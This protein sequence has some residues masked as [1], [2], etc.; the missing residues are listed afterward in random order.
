MAN[1]TLQILDQNGGVLFQ[2][3]IAFIPNSNAQQFMEAAVNQ[4]ANDQTLTFGAQYYGT[5]QASPL[6]YFINMINGI[7]DAPNSG[8]Y[9]EFL[10]NGEAA[11]AGID[12]VFPADGSAV[13]FQQTL[14]G[15]SS[16]AQL[17][18][19]HAFHQKRS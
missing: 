16:S 18:I 17:K 6:G 11:S 7:Y 10:Y 3:A 14:Y 13:A 8:A 4:V 5:F 12:A 15:A 9:W 1:A 2:D 19:K